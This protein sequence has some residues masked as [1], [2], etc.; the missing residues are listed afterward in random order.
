MTVGSARIRGAVTAVALVVGTGVAG[1]GPGATTASATAPPQDVAT[2]TPVTVTFT[3]PGEH[4]YTVP[5]GVTRVDV[6]AVG[7]EGARSAVR[8]GGRAA[9]I[10]GTLDVS[11][12]QTL[13]AV[14]GTSAS[15][16]S[17]GANGGGAAGGTAAECV[18][19]P[20]AGGGATDVRTVALGQPGSDESRVLVAGGGG[21]AGTLGTDGGDP[22][23]TYG[24][25]RG[26]GGA[27]AGLGGWGGVRGVGGDGGGGSQTDATSTAGGRGD[28]GVAGEG[29][30]CGG[31]GGGGYGGGGGGGAGAPG[32]RGGGGGGGGSLV[33]GGA[34]AGMAVHGET[35]SVT[36]S[37]PG[38]PAPAGPLRITSTET[39]K[40]DDQGA[41]QLT[42]TNCPTSC[43]WFDGDAGSGAAPQGFGYDFGYASLQAWGSAGLLDWDFLQSFVAVR[44]DTP[45]AAAD[46]GQPFVLAHF[47]H[48]NNLI[49]GDSPTSLALQT[50]LTVQPPAGP[51]AVFDMRG[52]RTIP[53]GFIETG[54][55]LPCDPSIQQSSTPCD[56]M[57]TLDDAYSDNT[58]VHQVLPATVTASGVTWHLDVL[59]WRTPAAAFDKRLATEEGHVTEG[60]IYAKITVDTIATSSTLAV[61]DPVAPVLTLTTTP[62]PQT[63]G[64]VTFTDGGTPI[65]GCTDVPV[66][67]TDGVTT[68]TPAGLAP[69]EHTFGGG[70]GGGVGYAASQAD[71][72][73]FTVGKIAT[74]TTLTATPDP[75]ALNQA[76]TLT[77][78]MS[79]SGSGAAPSGTV[80]FSVDG[81]AKPLATA[82]VVDGQATAKV[83]L[84]GGAHT[85]VAA[86][87]G[88]DTHE[89]SSSAPP[90]SVSVTCT[91][92]IS[93]PYPRSLT[94]T[95]GTTCV[96]PG[97]SVNGSITVTRGASLDVEGASVQGPVAAASPTA[98]RVCGS[99]VGSITVSRATG[100]VLVGDPEHGC[101]PDTTRGW[102]L[103]VN[104]SGGLVV[105][106]N[107]VGGAVLAY[108]NTG[109]GP[110]PG[111]E[112]PVISGNH[113]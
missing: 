93:G 13:Y 6:V 72:V 40:Q 31:G 99:S 71:P 53:L 66:D 17:P 43:R 88:D 57:F 27:P 103:V 92:T 112:Q 110:L 90:T 64:T 78:T 51:P 86:Y 42:F 55:Q 56:D 41:G 73:M 29:S 65:A 47:A 59:G 49:R 63:G 5:A 20:G 4:E 37:T 33:P 113:H 108:G 69:G 23:L 11:P 82:P 14:V 58:G 85:V 48:Y 18:N 10:V 46:P 35:P 81:A 80:A 67:A 96:L 79:P 45:G 50:L 28:V 39:F 77:A 38:L 76:V 2:A 21:G 75:A 102:L 22:E 52:A 84:P 9:H 1:V 106:G 62:V 25:H 44:P 107:T 19:T 91:R 36:F 68:C 16:T 83:L 34:P 87:S 105:V 3:A 30:G 111:Q 109:A 74:T 104:N 12:G 60:D 24:G 100:F 97:A 15:G 54:N 95:S 61:E 89:P 32:A 8:R 98:I 70:F 94:V 26:R 7:G 101:A